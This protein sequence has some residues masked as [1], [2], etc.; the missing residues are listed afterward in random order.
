MDKALKTCCSLFYNTT[1]LSL[2]ICH[3]IFC[4]NL[5]LLN[6]DLNALKVR[7]ELRIWPCRAIQTYDNNIR[8]LIYLNIAFSL[9]TKFAVNVL[10]YKTATK[11]KYIFRKCYKS[12]LRVQKYSKNISAATQKYSLIPANK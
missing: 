9:T 3:V 11:T 4:Y 6:S 12:L 7:L 10:N 2:F 5:L 8:Q 1:E